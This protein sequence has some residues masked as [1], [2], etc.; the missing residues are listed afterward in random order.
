M[1]MS[2]ID[3]NRL[4]PY[5][6]VAMDHV[7]P[8]GAIIRPRVLFDYEL[9]YVKEGRLQVT[10]DDG[11][12]TGAAGDLFLLKPGQRHAIAVVGGAPVRQ[13]H[14]HFDLIDR[15]DSPD[16]KVSF[17]P[18]EEMAPQ[19]LA[20]I[21]EDLC[22]SPP[23]ELP[24]LIRLHNPALFDSM[25]LHLIRD[26]RSGL[27]FAQAAAKGAFLRL[28]VYL[29]REQ[30]WSANKHLHSHWDRLT[31]V[32]QYID[33]HWRQS[34]TVDTLAGMAGLSPFY[35]LRL[36][37]QAFGLSPVKYHLTVRID[38]ARELIQFTAMSLTEIAEQTGFHSIHAF[39][40]AFRRIDGVAP[41]Y[42]R[43]G[44]AK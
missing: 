16:V 29:L 43:S 20:M 37:S 23:M 15:P 11:E 24:T 38:K 7:L 32:K 35:F 33:H 18:R 25:L 31:T 1:E 10:L 2:A 41:S 27:P 42:Y 40:R 19:E 21:R 26:Y 34:L 17:K 4:S 39:S 3:V 9:L 22:S 44:P 12:L 6:R 8:P 5:I 13:P 30:L 36:F 14:V 28:W